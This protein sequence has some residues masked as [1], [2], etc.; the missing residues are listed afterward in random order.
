MLHLSTNSF[1]NVEYI[2]YCDEKQVIYMSKPAY[3]MYSE[4]IYK[5]FTDF[6]IFRNLL[7]WDVTVQN[8]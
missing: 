5:Y 3:Y 1:T 7:L 8:V 6:D 2:M 4:W